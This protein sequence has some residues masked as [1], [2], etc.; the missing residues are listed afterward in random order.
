MAVT[1]IHWG[2]GQGKMSSENV[3]YEMGIALDE[4]LK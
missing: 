2:A 3:I 4:I 1:K